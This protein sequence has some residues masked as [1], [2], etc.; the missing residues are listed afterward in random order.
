MRDAFAAAKTALSSA[1]RLAH[2]VS[3][4]ELA[5]MSDASSSHVGA[6]LQQRLLGST[7]WWPLGFFSKKLDPAQLSYSAFDRELFAAYAAICHF[8]YQLEGRPFTL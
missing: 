2:P 4:A 8:R 5:L 7:C 6:V 1:V 3:A